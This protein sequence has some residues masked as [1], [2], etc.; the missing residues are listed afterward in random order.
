MQRTAGHVL[1]SRRY[2]SE[3]LQQRGEP[4]ALPNGGGLGGGNALI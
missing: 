1:A 4:E 3:P 2:A